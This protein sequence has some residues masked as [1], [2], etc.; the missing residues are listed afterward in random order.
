M[1]FGMKMTMGLVW[2]AWDI[3]DMW[4]QDRNTGF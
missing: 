1:G 3:W 4:N 2:D